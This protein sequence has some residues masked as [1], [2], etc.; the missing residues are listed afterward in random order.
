MDDFIEKYGPWAVITGVT[1]GTG[2]QFAHQLVEKGVHLVLVAWEEAL[3][4]TQNMIKDHYHVQLKTVATDLS[5]PNSI[6]E[7]EK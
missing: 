6:F 1:S 4:Q 5:I 2:Y 3:I 7:I